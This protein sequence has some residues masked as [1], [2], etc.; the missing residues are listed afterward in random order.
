METNYFECPNCPNGHGGYERTRHI[1]I[2]GAEECAASGTSKL[3]KRILGICGGISDASGL[4]SVLNHFYGKT[5]KC[6]KCGMLTVREHDGTI[7]AYKVAHGNFW[8]KK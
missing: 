8:I 1:Q 2:T 4:S 7:R 6:S 5:W 3:S